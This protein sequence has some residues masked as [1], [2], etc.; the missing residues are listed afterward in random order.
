MGR[1]ITYRYNPET[2]SYERIY[3]TL[4]RRL[5]SLGLYLLVGVAIGAVLFILS[6]FVLAPPSEA[7]LRKENSQLR[8]Q[9]NT[10]QRRLD[11]SLKVMDGI[12]QRDD[13]YYRVLMQME[14]LSVTERY[15]GIDNEERYRALEN[16][17]DASLITEL[18]HGLDLLDREM[19]VQSRSFDEL[20]NAALSQRDKLRHTPAVM[21]VSVKDYNLS[22]GFGYRTDPIYGT[23]EFHAGVDFSGNEGEPIAATAD[24]VVAEAGWQ[25]G[26]G[27]CV[28]I[29]HGYNYRTVYA[30]LRR[31]VVV[32][33]QRIS[34]GTKIGEM[35]STGKSTSLHLHYEVRFK[36]EAQN[37]VNY[38]FMDITPEQYDAMIRRA[39]NAG[40]VMD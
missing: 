1:Q 18:T 32:K 11:A 20:K 3:P 7:N 8:S 6:F 29:D 13:N 31:A 27:Y 12:R 30:H 9:Y 2:D 14:P 15:S 40:N 10:L 21:P 22:S 38:Y 5:V 39:D 36:G 19:Y 28:E 25:G 23:T 17:P 16:L 26:M 4:G 35:G 34:R 33:G 24:G 37:P